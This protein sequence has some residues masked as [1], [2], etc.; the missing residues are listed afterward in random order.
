[1]CPRSMRGPASSINTDRP[2]S[3]ACSAI[4]QPTMPVPAITH[5]VANLLALSF[6][7]LRKHELHLRANLPRR[8]EVSLGDVVVTG[9]LQIHGQLTE[10]DHPS[11]ATSHGDSP[12]LAAARAPV[13]RDDRA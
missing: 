8:P 11:Q 10:A 4:R 12:L 3:S 2:A 13:D 5:S 1:M 6:L 7:L 9:Q